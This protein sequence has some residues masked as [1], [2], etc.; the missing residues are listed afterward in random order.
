M[1][2]KIDKDE[3]LFMKIL[4]DKINEII[5]WV[6]QSEGLS[7]RT[8]YEVPNKTVSSLTPHN[9]EMAGETNG[10]DNSLERIQE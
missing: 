7:D 4:A 1:I 9:I 8:V 6:N 5:E 3:G 10:F 2:E